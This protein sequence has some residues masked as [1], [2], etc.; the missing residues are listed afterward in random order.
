MYDFVFKKRVNVDVMKVIGFS[1]FQNYVV[2][3][4]CNPNLSTLVE[5]KSKPVCIKYY[6]HTKRVEVRK[7]IIYLL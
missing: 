3:E 5:Y 2:V 6:P 1:A 4:Y 7:K